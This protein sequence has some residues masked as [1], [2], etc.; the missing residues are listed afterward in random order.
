MRFAGEDR[1]FTTADGL[2]IHYRVY[3]TDQTVGVP[4]LCLH[5]LTRNARDFEELAPKIAS[6][7]RR[8]VVASQR[9]RGLSDY[10]AV[11]ERYSP[12]I[13]VGDMLA[14]LDHLGID[15]AVYVGTS[16]GGLMTMLTAAMAPQRVSAAVLN[17]VGPEINPL[18]LARIR[19][20]AGV[21]KHAQTW[22]EA[23]ERC[24]QINGLAFPE[25]TQADFWLTFAKKIFRE[26]APG[27]IELDYDPAIAR[28]VQE[29][30]AD[31][32]DLWPLFDALKPIPTLL[33]RGELSDV[34][35]R[36]TVEEMLRRK[37][38]LH[39]ASVP[40][41]GHAPFMTEPEAWETLSTFLKHVG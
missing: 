7:G 12:A 39:T 13:Y 36:S 29:G 33:L 4:V 35:M 3:E 22:M 10:D 17:D 23:A 20:F 2:R 30:S 26:R 9:G 11:V 25:E 15:R 41:V 19:G 37:P 5:G 32:A 28:T 8:V 34:L 14:M 21:S 31:I 6:L 16:M 1:Y 40:A 18:G 24:R 38:D 27:R